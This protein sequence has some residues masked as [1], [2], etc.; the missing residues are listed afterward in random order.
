MFP[1]IASKSSGI[2]VHEIGSLAFAVLILIRYVPFSAADCAMAKSNPTED[3]KFQRTLKNLL[4]A[5]P[6]PH[7]EMKIGKGE[8]VSDSR[9]QV[10]H[11]K[12]A[13]KKSGVSKK[14]C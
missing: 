9:T 13:P 5:K 2:G 8:K 14:G 1:V 11:K 12:S 4:A 6:K 7:S 3:P 10:E